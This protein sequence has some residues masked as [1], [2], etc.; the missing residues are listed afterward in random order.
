MTKK[1]KKE[2]SLEEMA[3]LQDTAIDTTDIPEL[4]DE[5]FKNARLVM[6]HAKKQVTMRIDEDVIEWFKT[7]GKGYQTR[8]NSVLKAYMQTHKRAG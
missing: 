4:G 1:F 6:P 5:F 3:A 7:Q 2:L 8:M